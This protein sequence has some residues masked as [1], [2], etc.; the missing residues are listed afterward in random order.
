MEDGDFSGNLCYITISAFS[1]GEAFYAGRDVVRL[2][3][4]SG[5]ICRTKCAAFKRN[6]PYTI[7]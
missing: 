7:V 1:T 3:T 4:V 5:G 2:V 6:F